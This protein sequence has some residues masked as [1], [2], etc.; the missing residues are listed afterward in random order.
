MPIRLMLTGN[1]TF[2]IGAYIQ[3]EVRNREHYIM[4]SFGEL[5][6]YIFLALTLFLNIFFGLK[7]L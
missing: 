7:M 4:D 1:L 6:G 5:L 3:Y 2:L